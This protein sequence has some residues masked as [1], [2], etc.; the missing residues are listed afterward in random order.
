M[1]DPVVSQVQ[2][3]AVETATS[4]AKLAADRDSFARMYARSVERYDD[5]GMGVLRKIADGASLLDVLNFVG[6]QLNEC[7][8]VDDESITLWERAAAVAGSP[9]HEDERLTKLRDRARLE[10]AD[11][12]AGERYHA[13]VN[14][15]VG[16]A[17]EQARRFA[18]EMVLRLAG[19]S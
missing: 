14:D 2:G 7:D 10:I 1:S 3:E 9:V 17:S 4:V 19:E 13:E 6:D 8:H 15:G 12:K 16:L 18:W 5:L 11:A